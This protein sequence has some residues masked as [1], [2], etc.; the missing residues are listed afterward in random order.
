LPF[1]SQGCS[2]SNGIVDGWKLL[3]ASGS[4]ID[5]EKI[6]R[7]GARDEPPPAAT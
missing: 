7:A 2:E 4:D 6:R 1:T 5:V 3:S